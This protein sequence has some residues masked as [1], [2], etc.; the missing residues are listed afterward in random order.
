MTEE[1]NETTRR[2]NVF[3]VVG[4]L[5]LIAGGK[6]VMLEYRGTSNDMHTCGK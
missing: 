5:K 2:R 4:N 1:R 3:N 6:H